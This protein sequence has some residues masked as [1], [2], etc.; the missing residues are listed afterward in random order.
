MSHSP[1]IRKAVSLDS[2]QLYRRCTIESPSFRTTEELLSLDQPFVG[3]QRAVESVN[4]GIQMQSEGYNLFAL[5][6]EETDKRSLLERLVNVQAESEEPGRDLCYVCNYKDEQKPVALVLPPGRASHL[7]SRMHKLASELPGV[8]TSAFESEEYQNQRHA[9]MEEAKE[10]EQRTLRQL[11]EK[12]EQKGLTIMSSPAG[13]T[14]APVKNG[15]VMKQDEVNELPDEERKKMEQEILDFQK[16]V[17]DTLHRMPGNQRQFR[18]RKQELNKQVAQY[19]LQELFRELESEFKDQP[20]VLKYLNDTREDIIANINSIM[21]PGESNPL[22][23]MQQGGQVTQQERD[24][25][26]PEED[27]VLWRYTVNVLVDNSDVQGAPVIYEDNPTFTYLLG[28][29][30]HITHM[31]AVTTDFTQVMPGSLHRANGG[32]LLIDAFRI[33][34][35]PYAWDGLK[36][37]LQAG[38]LK[39][40]S[41]GEMYGLLSTKSLEPDAVTLNVKVILFGDRLLYYLLCEYD[42]DFNDLFKVQVDFENEMDWNDENQALYARLIAD[43]ARRNNLLPLDRSGVERVIEHAARMS[44]DREKLTAH[45]RRVGDLLKEADYWTRSNGNSHIGRKEIQQTIDHQD[46]R[47]ARLRDRTQEQILRDTVFIDTEGSRTGQVNGLSVLTV[48]N[49]SFGRPTR[50]TARVQLGRGE[51]INIEREVEMSG[52]IHSKGVLILS[53]FL[54]SRYALDN[55]LSISASL[56]FEQSY[57]G[58]DGDSASST[59]LYA[60]LSAIAEV[61]LRQDIA[62]TGSVNQHGRVQP[63]GGVNEKIEGFYDICAHRG[64]TGEQGVLIPS[65]NRKHLMLKSDV[66][67]AVEQGRF[68]IWPVEHID[69]GMELLTGRAMGEPDTDGRFPEGSINRM[70]HECLDRYAHLRQ[71][72]AGLSDGSSDRTGSSN[73]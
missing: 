28:R 5:G 32:Y 51:V 47:A 72:Y 2:G 43:L 53:S 27:P 7:R 58:V 40:E 71:R 20:K 63:I 49:T 44:D 57:A 17:Q 10:E 29:I 3:Q 23:A 19:A 56:V 55:P 59:E 33:L 68:H 42:Q 65:A 4:F 36:R 69:Q 67:Q 8:L 6:P 62:I 15:R 11:Q 60:L 25:S 13:F 70:V 21:N 9:I 14:I 64:L 73:A 45:I 31:G 61:P 66:V 35:Q 52:P 26:S 46:Y 12:A 48:G 1:Q 30:E 16:E 18:E 37:A 41:P 34:T 38:K 22:A 54:G 50:I 24:S 39:I